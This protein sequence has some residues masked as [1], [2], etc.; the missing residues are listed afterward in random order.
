MTKK[1]A[2]NSVKPH[3]QAKLQFYT[4]Y[5]RRYLEILIR[6]PGIDKINIYDML[7]GEGVY[8]DGNTGS[9]V[10]AIDAIWEAQASNKKNKIINLH[11]NDLDQ[12]K[13]GKLEIITNNRSSTEKNFSISHSRSEAFELLNKLCTKFDEH[14]SASTRNLIF[15][16]PYGYKDIKKDILEKSL[17]NG[18]TEI[19]LWLPIEQMYRFMQSANKEEVPNSHKPLVKF[20][21]QFGL[22]VGEINSEKEFID[23]LVP[24]LR[25]TDSLFATSYAIRNQAGRY[26]GMFFISPNLK[27]LEKIMEVKWGLDAQQGEESDQ[28]QRDFFLESDKLDSFEVKLT[29]FLRES[30]RNNHELYQ[31]VLTLG[32][33]PSHANEIFRKWQSENYLQVYEVASNKTARRG[34]FKLTYNSY[35]SHK[36]ELIF[37]LGNSNDEQN[38]VD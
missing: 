1:D 14:Q 35:K 27:G 5:L 24:K 21:N 11:L 3:T 20:M 12:S 30:D 37:S 9:A 10:R 36:P 6:V 7:C 2:R 29:E 26:Y 25:F 8:S 23:A 22:D 38:R 33:K 32:F 16:D 15:I 18:K 34:T 31:F 13:V 17:K 4:Q 28:L 19:I